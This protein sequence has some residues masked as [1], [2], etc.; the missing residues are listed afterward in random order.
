MAATSVSSSFSLE[1][2]Q[3]APEEIRAV[4]EK[5]LPELRRLKSSVEGALANGITLGANTLSTIKTVDVTTDG[6]GGIVPLKVSSELKNDAKPIGVQVLQAWKKVEPST[7]FAC[8]VAWT[9]TG[10]GAVLVSAFL[11]LPVS[12]LCSV[13]LLIIGG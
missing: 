6:S 1:D 5:L 11:G 9:D 13:R 4:L 2:Y 7:P 10:Q 12:T 8:A 3:D